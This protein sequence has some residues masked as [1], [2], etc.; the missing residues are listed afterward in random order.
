MNQVEEVT[1]ASAFAAQLEGRGTGSFRAIT[2]ALTIRLPI[3]QVA[4]VDA[5][6]AQANCSR[7]YAIST[8][9]EIGLD[10]LRLELDQKTQKE[11]RKVQAQRMRELLDSKD[12]SES[13][14]G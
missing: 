6:A 9:I 3:D 1:N 8:L 2:H 5:L 12:V 10:G 11:V 13:E 7:T 14:E 4:A